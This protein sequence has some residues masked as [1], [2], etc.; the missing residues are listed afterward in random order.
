M[1]RS[2]PS[3]VTDAEW[4]LIEEFMPETKEEGR[5]RE[6]DLREV[7]NS[8]FYILRSGCSWRMMP[9]DL[10]AWQTAYGYFQRWEKDGTIVK[11]SEKLRRKVR[12][13]SGKDDDPTGGI[14]DSQSV[15]TTESKG[16]RGYDGGKKVNGRKRH[17]LTDTDGLV[18]S[19]SVTPANYNDRDGLQL[20]AYDADDFGL[21]LKKV[22]VDTGYLGY[23]FL[24]QVKDMVGWIVEVV[25]RT[26]ARFKVLPKRWVVERTFAWINKYRRLSKD[27]EC[28]TETSEAFIHLAMIRLMLRRL[29][30]RG[31]SAIGYRTNQTAFLANCL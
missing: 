7:V 31:H 13:Q 26:D 15:K 16:T 12:N 27:Y 28:E 10:V 1:R 24:H 25:K 30:G 20:L 5:E 9:H 14:V 3:D 8:I 29:T 18:L 17:L 4:E 6:V 11:I 23:A 22:W 2:Y 19:V 21:R